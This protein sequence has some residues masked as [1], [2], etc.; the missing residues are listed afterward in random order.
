MSEISSIGALGDGPSRGSA[1]E[2]SS[3]RVPGGPAELDQADR[4]R[5]QR[6]S[7][8]V[9]LSSEARAASRVEPAAEGGV[10]TELVARV[11]AQ[12]EART[13]YTDEKLDAAVE[14]LIDRIVKG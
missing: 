3:G 5:R 10:R 12:L 7:D 1:V 2:R 13:Y 9:N 8:S 6:S 11:R 4:A 14:T